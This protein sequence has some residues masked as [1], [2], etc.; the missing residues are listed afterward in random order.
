MKRS[1]QLIIGACI[2]AATAAALPAG[3]LAIEGFRGATWGDLRWHLPEEGDDNL[4]LNGWIRQG[5]DWAKWGN[6]TL[7]TYGILQYRWDTERLDWNN[8][9]GPGVGIALDTYTMEGLVLSVGA[10]YIWESRILGDQEIEQ[11]AVVY[12]GW[13]G[14]WDLK[15]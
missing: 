5:I 9:F 4:V 7:N 1:T 6:T 2:V 10:E 13:Y 3:A 14:W 15:R 12:M 8:T 11:K